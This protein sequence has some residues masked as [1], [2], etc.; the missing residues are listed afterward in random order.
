[1]LPVKPASGRAAALIIRLSLSLIAWAL[2]Q[3]LRLLKTE[4]VHFPA[5]ILSYEFQTSEAS[6]QPLEA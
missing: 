1:M 6:P 3:R 2:A 5:A 4:A